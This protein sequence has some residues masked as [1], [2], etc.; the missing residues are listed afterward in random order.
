MRSQCTGLMAGAVLFAAVAVLGQA[1]APQPIAAELPK[2]VRGFLFQ[3]Q[4]HAQGGTPPLRWTAVSGLPPGLQLLPDGELSGTPSAAGEFRV[5]VKI[6][7]S[8]RPPQSTE[9]TVVLRVVPPIQIEWKQAP[10]VR[11]G[12]IF[13]AAR[14]VNNTPNA[15]DLTVIIV[16]VNS[17]G[18]AFALGYQHGPLAPGSEIAVMPFGF[19]LSA[20]TYIVHADAI[21]EFAT[22]GAIYRDRKQTPA[23]KVESP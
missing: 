23:M 21:A 7:D 4:L 19:T 17:I 10:A 12:G 14:I 8:A 1:P 9:F 22:S 16:A 3:A 13:G 6:S 20:D 11:G 2:A 5:R 15:V 18:K